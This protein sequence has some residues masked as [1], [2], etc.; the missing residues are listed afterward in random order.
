[1]DDA[2]GAGFLLQSSEGTGN[3]ITFSEV[4]F[5]AITNQLTNPQRVTVDVPVATYSYPNQPP[6]QGTSNR[7][8]LFEPRFWSCAIRNGS[9]WAVH[10]VNESR[11]RVRWYEF[12]LR[13]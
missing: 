11:A 7:P 3:G 12:D 6:Q 13:N 8:F 9:L 2:G 5:H 1:Y 4:R 10:H